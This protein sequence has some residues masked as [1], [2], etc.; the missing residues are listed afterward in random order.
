MT[1]K[2]IP[3]Y[4]HDSNAADDIRF[5]RLMT[6]IQNRRIDFAY[7]SLSRLDALMHAEGNDSLEI[8]K[9]LQWY[10]GKICA[11]LEAAE[12]NY[13]E[14]A[15]YLFTDHG[16]H[17]V[18]ETHDL[19]ADIEALGLEW[20]QDYV[21]FYDSTMARF[22]FLND[23]ARMAI[24]RELTNHSKGRILSVAELK[25][26]GVY[27][28]TGQ[29]GELIFLMNSG[30]QIIPGFMGTHPAKGMHGYDPADPDSKASLSS[31]RAL[32]EDINGIRH[33]HR[34][35]LAELGLD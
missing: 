7:C 29:Y 31:N 5:D 21:A 14:V 20:N 4:V 11:L 27:F 17:N 25:H 3:Y 19:I 2:R 22:W 8:G 30:I 23:N 26:F 32:P 1:E 13:D 6:E 24:T 18:I 34:L 15:W 35:M 16:M 33:I 12:E 10:D 28:E 9:L